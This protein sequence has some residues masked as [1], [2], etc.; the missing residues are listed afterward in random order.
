MNNRPSEPPDR[1]KRAVAAK[2]A[3]A[4]APPERSD[5][6]MMRYG[7]IEEMDRSFYIEFWQRQ[8]R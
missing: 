1:R 5:I 4:S 2:P 8:G 7:R 3:R 6:V